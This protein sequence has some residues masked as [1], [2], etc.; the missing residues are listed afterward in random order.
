MAR[1]NQFD[2]AA[3][4]GYLIGGAHLQFPGMGR[5][6]AEGRGYRWIPVNFSQMR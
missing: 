2:A 4:G 5:L 1:K 3:K 6:R